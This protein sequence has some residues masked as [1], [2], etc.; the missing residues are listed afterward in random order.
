MFPF[1]RNGPKKR[2]KGGGGNAGGG[3]RRHQDNGGG[4]GRRVPGSAGELLSMMQSS[5]KA[6]AQMLAGNTRMSGQLVH[7]RGVLAQAN[8]MVDE[9]M[10]DRLPPAAREQFFQQ[11]AYLKLTITDAEEAAAVADA[12]PEPQAKPVVPMDAE[13]LRDIARRLAT[14]DPAPPPPVTPVTAGSRRRTRRPARPGQCDQRLYA[15]IGTPVGRGAGRERGDRHRA[16]PRAAAAE[17]RAADSSELG[18]LTDVRR[19]S[20]G[21]CPSIAFSRAPAGMPDGKM[22]FVGLG[23]WI[24]FA[25]VIMLVDAATWR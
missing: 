3:G 24:M 14:A 8:R 18:S 9:R 2:G 23:D 25:G 13:R 21:A 17:A 19:G 22:A 12:A 1:R 20:P 15:P 5:T 7:A 4:A 6:L 16:P 10:P 11:L